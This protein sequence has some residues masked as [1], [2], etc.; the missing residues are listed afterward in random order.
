MASSS[1]NRRNARQ[2]V[3]SPRR[4]VDVCADPA[5]NRTS[6]PTFKGGGSAA[7]RAD[8]EARGLGSSGPPKVPD[9]VR[10]DRLRALS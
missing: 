3:G 6:T 8:R 10:I 4:G 9:T 5:G 2:A 7:T 1:G